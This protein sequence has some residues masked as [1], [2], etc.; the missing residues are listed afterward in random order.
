MYLTRNVLNNI[1]STIGFFKAESGGIIAMN[2]EDVISDYY[3]DT[4]AGIGKVSYVPSRILIQNYIRNNWSSS[5][6]R[7]CGVVHS[8]PLCNTCEPSYIDIEM[9][10]KIMSTNNMD[11]FYLLMV[12]GSEMKLFLVINEHNQ[13]KYSCREEKIDIY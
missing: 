1:Q 12:K 8:H 9:A 2:Q 13:G 11:K 4:D 7:F 3:F 5:K 10:K 6:L